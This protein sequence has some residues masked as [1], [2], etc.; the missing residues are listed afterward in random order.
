M[1]LQI[2]DLNSLDLW[3][4][5][6]KVGGLVSLLLAVAV[7]VLWRKYEAKDQQLAELN[8]QAN[9]DGKEN[10]RV[11]TSIESLLD[12]ILAE[13]K[14]GGK[15]ILYEVNNVKAALNDLRE[16]IAHKTRRSE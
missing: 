4:S 1:I 5:I 15:R 14:D 13:Q 12:Q 2:D 6:M 7:V 10:I 9:S 8:K 3:T 16:K 11:I